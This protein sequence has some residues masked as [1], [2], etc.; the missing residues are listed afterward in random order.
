MSCENTSCEQTPVDCPIC[1]ECIVGNINKV[2]TECGHCFHTKCLM[3]NIAHN[4]FGCPFCR[5]AMADEPEDEEDEVSVISLEDSINSSM[6]GR[7]EEEYNDYLLYNST[8][9]SIRNLFREEGEEDEDEEEEEEEE[10]NHPKPPIEFL[11]QKMEEQGFTIERFVKAM[12]ID[13]EEYDNI[14][15]ECDKEGDDIWEALRVLISN[16]EE[17]AQVVVN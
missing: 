17:P 6:R 7:T 8:L 14:E 13:H 16:Y 15:E 5:T 12:L 4:G 3:T 10:E 9:S 11:A 2:I 1:M